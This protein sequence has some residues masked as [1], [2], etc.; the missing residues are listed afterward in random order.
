MEG[1]DGMGW[2]RDEFWSG[3]RSSASTEEWISGKVGV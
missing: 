1:W 2:V 3:L